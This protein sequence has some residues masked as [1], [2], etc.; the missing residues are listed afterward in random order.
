[1][2][3]AAATYLSKSF[4]AFPL[5]I[6][7]FLIFQ[8][9]QKKGELLE[10][11]PP[12]THLVYE[13]I[14]LSGEN[15][16]NTQVKLSWFGTDVDGYITGYEISNN[17]QDWSFT[18]RQ[19][20]VFKFNIPAGSDTFDLDF[21][22]RAVDNQEA[23]DETPAYLSIPLKNT[24]PQIEI[25]ES[26]LP[27]DSV[28]LVTAFQYRA[29]DLDG[30]ESIVKIEIKLNEGNWVE[31]DRGS[32]IVTILP[33]D[34]RAAGISTAKI[35]ANNRESSENA[36][37]LRMNDFNTFYLRATDD[38]GAVSNIDTSNSFYIRNQT[39]D[40]LLI[41]GHSLTIAQHYKTA[42]KNLNIDYDFLDYGSNSGKNQPVFW[43]PTFGLMLNNYKILFLN[44]SGG[45]FT[46]PV[47]GQS[48]GIL[49]FGAQFIQEFIN[50]PGKKYMISTRFTTN[51][52]LNP[53][54]GVLPVEELVTSQGQ[55]RI[56]AGD[57]L[58]PQMT[59]YPALIPATTILG[60]N[61]FKPTTDAQAFYRGQLTKL[62]GWDGDNVLGARRRTSVGNTLR[63]N[64][65]FF[66]I[67]LH[68]FRSYTAGF[69]GMIEKVITDDFNW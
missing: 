23:R 1:M 49:E 20:S 21:Y 7:I 47:T 28:L 6:F 19:D 11:I 60:P 30:D 33:T 48:G 43:N 46:N 29:S 40:L 37:D 57:S 45:Q 9:C 55:V 58:L 26:T 69:E 56:T 25:I 16:L 3:K 42:L 8:A 63:V 15:R 10:N 50:I 34:P 22:V 52:D 41:S 17:K 64:Q 65:V 61:P 53:L 51:T 54:L 62:Q 5:F 24:A 32:S 2:R 4:K 35:I 68:D 13:T 67:Q 12:D 44:S 39:S 36:S 31:V 38:A 18:T 14:N 66:G 59:G 27:Q